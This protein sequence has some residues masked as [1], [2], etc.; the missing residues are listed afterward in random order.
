[1]QQRMKV[2]ALWN[3]FVNDWLVCD[4]IALYDQNL[5]E[6]I[7]QHARRDQTGNA[8]ADDNRLLSGPVTHQ[9]SW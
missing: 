7:G 6:V 5:L 4:L 9:R 8:A 2:I 1:M 3:R